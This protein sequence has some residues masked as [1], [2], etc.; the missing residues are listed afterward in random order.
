MQFKSSIFKLP[1]YSRDPNK[2]H[3]KVLIFPILLQHFVQEKHLLQLFHSQTW[4]RMKKK[5]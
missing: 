4:N 1:A 3:H 5:S 2:L